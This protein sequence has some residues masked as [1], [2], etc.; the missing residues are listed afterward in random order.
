MIYFLAGVGGILVGFSKAG[1]KG[2]GVLVVALLA[3]AYGAKS[4]TGIVLPLF[5]LGDVFAVIYFNRYAQWKY[6]IRFL[7]AMM[8]GVVM[9]TYFG[10][11]LDERSFQYVMSVIIL[12]SVVIMIYFER[13][14]KLPF[15]DHWLFGSLMGWSAG[16]STMLGNLAGPFSNLYFLATKIP[17]NEFIGTAAWLFFII[18]IFKMPFHIFVWETVSMS[19]L[20]IS[21][22]LVPFVLLGFFIGLRI[23][24][25]ITNT[26]YRKF[27]IGVTLLSS[28]LILLK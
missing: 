4:S 16:F 2:L 23:V 3:L 18:N 27:I 25:L 19:S 11:D 21:L 22:K 24:A 17:K 8:V 1:L 14:A 12:I 26:Y 13:L 10:I 9:G 6:L 5:L 15:A 28:I 7:P 20:M